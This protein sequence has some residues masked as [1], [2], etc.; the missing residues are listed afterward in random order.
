MTNQSKLDLMR[1]AQKAYNELFGIKPELNK[2][3]LL[4]YSGRDY[5]SCA[6]GNYDY[7][8]EYGKI[9]QMNYTAIKYQDCFK[10]VH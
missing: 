1:L 2:I 4:E 6:I 10:K 3:V 5:L 7:T 8:I 9:T